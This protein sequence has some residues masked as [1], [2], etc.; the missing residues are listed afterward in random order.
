MKIRNTLLAIAALSMAAA[1]GATDNADVLARVQLPDGSET[2]AHAVLE[3]G[4]TARLKINDDYSIDLTHRQG[5]DGEVIYEYG[6]LR[7]NGK[8][9]NIL[10]TATRRMAE[11]SG[12]PVGYVVCGDGVMF[13]S[14][15]EAVMPACLGSA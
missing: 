11:T 1:A 9:F 6:F 15:P 13:V 3:R 5:E 8:A 2:T 10:H 4:E 12:M 7:W 14:H